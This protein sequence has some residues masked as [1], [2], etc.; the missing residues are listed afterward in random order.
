M[1]NYQYENTIAKFCVTQEAQIEVNGE[2][3]WRL[4]V[5]PKVK[6]SSGTKFV[7]TVQPYQHQLSEE[8][9]QSYDYWKPNF[10]Y[11]LA[12][13]ESLEIDVKIEKVETA[14][15]HIKR[16]NDSCRE[17]HI[18]LI[19]DFDIG[20]EFFIQF[21]GVDRPFLRGDAAPSRVG[22]RAYNQDVCRLEKRLDVK[23]AGENDFTTLDVFPA[24]KLLPGKAH[25]IS[26]IAPTVVAQ[27]E[28]FKL[29]MLALDRFENPVP[30][31]QCSDLTVVFKELE[32]DK[33]IRLEHIEFGDFNYQLPNGRYL[34]SVENTSLCVAPAVI[35]VEQQPQ[36]RLYWGDTHCHSNLTANIRDNDCGASPHN[37]YHYAQHVAR[38]D[39]VCL[40]EQTFTFNEDRRVNIDK[41]TWK[42]IGSVCDAYNQEG[43]FVTFC[44]F[45][46]HCQR[47]DTVVL[48]RNS[49]TEEKY[50]DREVNII[51]DVWD[52]YKGRDFIT[53][54]H[55]H[56]FCNGRN[57]KHV[58]N[59][60]AKFEAGFDLKNWEP[61]SSD[62]TMAEVYSAQWGRFEYSKNPMILKA[63]NNVKNNTVVD[64]LKRG[65]KWGFV[66]N[67]DGHDG[68]PGY[69]G[70]TGVL[71][72]AQTRGDIFDA[73]KSRQ[74]IATTHPRMFLNLELDQSALGTT[75][76]AQQQHQLKMDVLT[77]E[78][79]SK[80]ELVVDGE[81]F[82]RWNAEG[83][84][85]TKQLDAIS[86]GDASF[87]YLRVFQKD[88]HIGW[89][90]PIWID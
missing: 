37:A 8:Y 16:W 54:P 12:E 2:Y 64:F 57:P 86:L 70:V 9:L 56:R 90:S 80:V 24:I 75:V 89:T 40:S 33:D 44:G 71:A 45:E 43:E 84:S 25:T 15:S 68:N 6:L 69:G 35:K 53:I 52:C 46:L 72:K 21:G 58:D 42:T 26:L 3:E 27:E 11:A 65:K 7:I 14:F 60:D 38:M 79:I 47:G 19:D 1:N 66:S 76:C 51:H 62:E 36:N 55:L 34:V 67:S 28:P 50:P 61:S 18:T 4:T 81:V 41:A 77:P 82:E 22:I 85:F 20:Q 29:S 63:R 78:P 48:Y 10:I 88:R 17:A 87:I 59:Q 39:F 32:S 30:D 13:E 49:M 74:T 23:L 83:H 5:E 31:Y 73:M